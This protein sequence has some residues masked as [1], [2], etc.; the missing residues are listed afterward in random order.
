L[1]CVEVRAYAAEIVFCSDVFDFL[2]AI[3]PN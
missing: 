2:V 3:N 1:R